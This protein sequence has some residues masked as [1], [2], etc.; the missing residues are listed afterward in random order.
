MHITN[1]SR[2]TNKFANK[3][4]AQL[5]AKKFILAVVLAGVATVA[6]LGMQSVSADGLAS[7]TSRIAD[8]SDNSIIKC[9]VDNANDVV[10][11]IN[12]DKSGKLKGLYAE[13]GLK[14]A[15]YATFKKE[16]K[17][18]MVKKATGEIVVDGK[19][20]GTNGWSIGNKSKSYSVPFK[21][22]DQTYYKSDSTDVLA[23]DLPVLVWINKDTGGLK[24]VVIMACGNPMGGKSVKPSYTCDELQYK[25]V[26]GQDNTYSFTTDA[27]LK[28]MVDISKVV[29][30]F[31]DKTKDEVRLNPKDAVVHTFKKDD[32]FSVKVTVYVKL[33]NG[34]EVPVNGT[35]CVK[36]I[37]IKT[38]KEAAWQCVELKATVKSNSDDEYVYTLRANGK[39][40]NATLV[41]VDFDYG[42]GTTQKDVK[43]KA[44]SDMFVSTN[45][46]YK[47][48][49]EQR[50]VKATLTFKAKSGATATNAADAVCTATFTINKP[51]APVV[52]TTTTPTPKTDTPQVLSAATAAVTEL[53]NTG[54]GGLVG[55]FTG[56]SILGTVGYRWFARRRIAKVDDLIERL[57]R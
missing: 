40:T 30:H 46:T 17:L 52:T 47:S 26:E 31:D 56:T 23:Q 6:G 14:S 21:V 11:A 16:A 7:S 22:G 55:V 15:D 27:P 38:P 57:R 43:P 37:T 41:S 18:G 54:P 34:K 49:T 45:H 33:A 53:P 9:G 44:T 4:V 36:K 51:T 12:G 35:G 48:V 8:C 5:R 13:A 3:T 25:K 1:L 2:L 24:A 39:A 20:V 50:T 29:Y 32:T 28:G 19:V 42:D 10:A